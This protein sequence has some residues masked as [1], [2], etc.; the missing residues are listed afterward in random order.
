MARRSE[1]E[2]MVPAWLDRAVAIGWRVAFLVA[3]AF[4]LYLL[5]TYLRLIV[6]PVFVAL[7][8]TAVI[9]PLVNILERRGIHRLAGT[10]IVFLGLTGLAAGFLVYVIPQLI[11]EF[12]G[13]DDTVAEAADDIR[14][15]LVDGPIGLSERQ[16]DDAF[17]QV[18]RQFE[19]NQE[20][21]V[22]GVISG[23][24]TAVE[25]I[26]GALVTLVLTFFFVKD[27]PRMV[28]WIQDQTPQ[29]FGRDLAEV[30]RRSWSSLSAY[31]RGV[32]IDGL[33]EG[34][35]MAIALIILGVPLV[36]P[37]AILTFLGGYVPFIGAT[38]AGTVTAM[39]ALA[40]RGLG[41]AVV[42]IIVTIAIQNLENQLL[43]PLV[44]GKVTKLHPVVVLVA[45]TTGG[46]LG[47][48]PGL[49]V[50]VPITVVAVRVAT[51]FIHE[52]EPPEEPIDGSTGEPPL[53]IEAAG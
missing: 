18:E 9:A 43:Q 5:L 30:G 39:V 38:L 8:A 33:I 11:D 49:F 7:V 17:G 25:I 31:F 27:G 40:T 13:L 24:L 15:W 28:G 21:L 53:P 41:A 36:A 42:V 46:I 47:G 35:L 4:V 6:L 16:I 22:Q 20:T 10:W 44:M 29:R 37:L 23:A 26:V 52:R 50:A 2:R 45:V 3:V 19:D 1:D 34:T 32:T 12:E 14:E 48:I 51:Y